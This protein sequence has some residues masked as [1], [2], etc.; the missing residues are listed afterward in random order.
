[1][2]ME[3]V[4]WAI[5]G[6]YVGVFAGLF[7]AGL[8]RAAKCEDEEAEKLY[9]RLVQREPDTIQHVGSASYG[10]LKGSYQSHY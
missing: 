4:L 9:V 10:P 5:G 7:L 3:C 1:M 6:L 8:L 2:A